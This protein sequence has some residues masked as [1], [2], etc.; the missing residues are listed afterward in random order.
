MDQREPTGARSPLSNLPPKKTR[1]LPQSF[2]LGELESQFGAKAPAGVVET[3][4]SL[5]ECAETGLQFAWPMLP[6]NVVFYEWISSFSSYYPGIRWEYRKIREVLKA[7]GRLSANSKVLD[8]GS[9][10]GDFLQTFDLVST[11][12][13]YALDLNSPAV[14][15]CRQHGIQAFCGT[16]KTAL[17]EGFLKPGDFTVVTSFHCLEHVSEPVSFV[18]DLIKVTASGGRVFVSTPYSPMSTEENAFDILNHPPHHLTRWN[19]AAYQRLAGLLGVKM[20]YFVPPAGAFKRALKSFWVKR[21]GPNKPIVKAKLLVDVAAHLPEVYELYRRH[22]E[23]ERAN[24]GIGADVI[25]VEFT[26]S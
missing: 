10:K 4:Y 5:W 7:E 16:I 20:R 24:G 2:L 19:L 23:R 8:A 26:V 9:G 22:S 11:A 13:K 17:D 21:N 1:D 15:A 6:G 18:R 12:N 25:L 14:V 3:D